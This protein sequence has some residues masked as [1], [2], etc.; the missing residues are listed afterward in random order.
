MHVTKTIIKPW[1]N[2]LDPISHSDTSCYEFVFFTMTL[3][4]WNDVIKSIRFESSLIWVFFG[5][6]ETT[7]DP[8]SAN[9][10]SFKQGLREGG[11]IDLNWPKDPGKTF[12]VY[13]LIRIFMYIYRVVESFHDTGVFKLLPGRLS[14]K[15]LENFLMNFVE[16]LGHPYILSCKFRLAGAIFFH[17]ER[18][19]RRLSYV[20]SRTIYI[21]LYLFDSP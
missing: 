15:L 17:F 7:R 14:C 2:Q 3:I 8:L 9:W 5:S 13:I 18:Y 16:L 19:K 4:V 1:V 6:L 12:H 11:Q 20:G 10:T 21:F